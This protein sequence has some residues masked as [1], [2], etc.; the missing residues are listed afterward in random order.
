MM[1]SKIKSEN[2]LLD[3]Q[4]IGVG[5]GRDCDSLKITRRVLMNHC[6]ILQKRAR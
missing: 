3:G 5:A 2:I 6:Q 4:R 1:P